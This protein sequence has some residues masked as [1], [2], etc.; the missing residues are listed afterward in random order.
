LLVVWWPSGCNEGSLPVL[1]LRP[2]LKD[3]CFR[4]SVFLARPLMGVAWW[5]RLWWLGSGLLSGSVLR[6]I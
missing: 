4:R 5:L 2:W 6:I 3:V 1:R